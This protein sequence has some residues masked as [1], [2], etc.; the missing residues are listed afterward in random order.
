[1]FFLF[2]A[3]GT[4]FEAFQADLSNQLDKLTEDQR[5]AIRENLKTL[6]FGDDAWSMD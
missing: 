1:M 4:P 3:F 5:T 2:A 6:G